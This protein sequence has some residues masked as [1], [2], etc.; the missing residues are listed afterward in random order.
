MG[1]QPGTSRIGNSRRRR[2]IHIVV[3][4][5]RCV[6]TKLLSAILLCA[7]A[8]LFVV[9]CSESGKTDAKT[10]ANVEVPSAAVV[11]FNAKCPVSGD[12]VDAKIA[13][14][15]FHGEAIG[16]CCAK[17]PPNFKAMSDVDKVAAL[18]KHGA[19]LPM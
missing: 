18:A 7:C 15:S 8:A 5:V 12:P 17:C 4:E 6:M 11:A 19:K 13:T 9:G 3:V 14:V 1:R 10:K 16:F 2:T